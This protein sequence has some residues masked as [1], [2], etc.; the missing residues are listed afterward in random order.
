MKPAPTVEPILNTQSTSARTIWVVLF[1]SLLITSTFQI[2]FML[3]ISFIGIFAILISYVVFSTGITIE[4]N[5][6]VF[7][8]LAALF[9]YSIVFS[10]FTARSAFLALSFLFSFLFYCTLKDLKLSAISGNKADYIVLCKLAIAIYSLAHAVL[11]VYQ[12]SQNPVRSTGF[13][14]DY[15]QASIFILISF[16]LVYPYLK[17]LIV[18]GSVLTF[19]LFLGFFTTYSRT[20]NFLLIIMLGAIAVFE[21]KKGDIKHLA[22]LCI[23]I[24]LAYLCIYAYPLLVDANTVSRGGIS[25]LA[26]LNSRVYYWGSAI[27]AIKTHPF[28]GNGLGN[29]EYLGIK[30]IYPFHT[31]QYVHN[32]YLQVWVDL[33]L[34]W[35]LAFIAFLS[36]NL[37]HYRPKFS[38][39]GV[40]IT[41][42]EKQHIAL[43]RYLA[44]SLLAALCLY[45]LINFIV[46]SF[47]LQ[48]L[49][50]VI[51]VDLTEDD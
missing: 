7:L 41:A 50:V 37:L 51:F 19:I 48:I 17:K 42:M 13:F 28:M 47:L 8:V 38:D 11:L 18:P 30:D 43:T 21:W 5:R 33:G 20:S 2:R 34:F 14:L 15:S 25:Q 23:V 40:S 22:L 32:D 16:C 24:F 6:N 3:L 39:L 1:A 44:W 10:N 35:L 4:K 26:T 12:Y 31:I 9:I 36:R 46:H 45:M 49:I 29:F 27:D